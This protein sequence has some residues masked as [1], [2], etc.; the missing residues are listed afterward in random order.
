MKARVKSSG[1]IINVFTRP[2]K[3]ELKYTDGTNTYA[4]GDLEM[5]H[6]ILNAQP[7]TETRKLIQ[8]QSI[9]IVSGKIT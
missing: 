9:A 8:I 6:G 1:E 3:N 7:E 2:E 5:C 4:W